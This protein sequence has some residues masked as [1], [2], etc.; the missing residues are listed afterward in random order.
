MREEYGVE[1]AAH[2]RPQGPRGRHLR[3]HPRR[4]AG[5]P[6][7]R[8]A[9]CSRSS[10]RVESTLRAPRR[11]RERRSCASA[12]AS[13]RRSPGIASTWPPSS[14]TS[15]CD[16]TCSA[17]PWPGLD[18]R[19]PAAAARRAWSSPASWHRLPAAAERACT[20]IA[21]RHPRARCRALCAR[22]AQAGAVGIAAR[23]SRASRPAGLALA[24]G[25]RPGRL[26]ARSPARGAGGRPLRLA[27]RAGRARLPARAARATRPS[28]RSATTSRRP[29]A[30]CSP[31][32]ARARRLRLRHRAGRVPDR[33]HA[34]EQGLEAL[35]AASF[36][37]ALPAPMALAAEAWR[38]RATRR[39][40]GRSRP[41]SP[42]APDARNWTPSASWALFRDMEMPLARDPARHGGA[43]ASPWTR[44]RLD[45]IGD[46]LGGHDDRALR[47][48]S[49]R[50]R[51]SEFN[52]DSPK[53]L[54]QVL[55]E[56][57]ELP[58]GRKTKTGWSTD[59]D[60]LEELAAEHEIVARSPGVPRVRQAQVHL[61][62]R[63]A[64]AGHA[65]RRARAHHLRA[66]GGRD[67]A[68]VQPQPEPAEHPRSAP[69]GAARSARASWPSAPGNVLLSADYSQIELRILAH[70]SQDESLLE[71]FRAGEDI[72]RRTAA[73]IFG[74]AARRSSPAT[75]GDVAKTV[76]FAVIY[77]MGAQALA[78]AARHHARRGAAVHRQLLR[79]PAPA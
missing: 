7:D 23:A 59:A 3:Q 52:L 36:G 54:A 65:R 37:E 38:A 27:R 64:A 58:R 79:A 18:V 8:H 68:A 48:A 5:R 22:R 34:G 11:G 43:W 6:E 35:V 30:R 33:A 15:R 61:R 77:G 69:S 66:D 32:R 16:R 41:A 39:R 4:A 45:E 49:T 51:A 29:P 31:S 46:K 26:R 24:A 10:A 42:R 53:Q 12:C 40:A 63:P 62:R 70:L 20:R 55:F 71:A 57:L 28:P 60:V 14:P 50:W 47:A 72:H 56:K 76:N 78:R 44:Q 2:R 19:A 13:T 73:E 25:R 21:R 17:A 67:R 74:V 1:P 9:T 75:C